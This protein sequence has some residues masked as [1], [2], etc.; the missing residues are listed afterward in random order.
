MLIERF[1]DGQEFKLPPAERP[2]LYRR[3]GA[4]MDDTQSS[5][6]GSDGGAGK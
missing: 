3:G 4:P 1:A 2:V 5:T 6:P